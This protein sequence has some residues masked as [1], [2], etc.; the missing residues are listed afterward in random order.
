M[1]EDYA[2][3]WDVYQIILR[4]DQIASLTLCAT[5]TLVLLPPGHFRK[6]I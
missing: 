3:L 2:K 6:D 5:T 4:L 1:M